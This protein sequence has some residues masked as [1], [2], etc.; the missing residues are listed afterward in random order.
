[1]RPDL[2]TEA[3]AKDYASLMKRCD[4]V[5]RRADGNDLLAARRQGVCGDRVA[6]VSPVLRRRQVRRRRQRPAAVSSARRITRTAASRRPTSSIRWRRSS[7]CSARRS[8]KSFLEPFMNYA[9]SDRWKFPFAPHDLGT[10]PKANGQ[11]YGG[12]EKTEENQMPVEESGNMLL[13]MAALAQM[14]GNADFASQYWPQLTAVGRVPEATRVRSREPA[15]HRRLRRATWR[16]TS[17]CRR[18]RSVRWARM[19]S[20]ARCAATTSRRPSTARSREEFAARW[21]KEADDG[22]HYRLTFDR[23]GTWSQKYNLVWDK[24]LGLNLFPDEVRRKEMDFYLKIAE[25]LRPAARQPECL[26]EA[27]LDFVDGD[28]DA[29]SRGLRR[30]GDARLSRSS[31][32]RPIVRR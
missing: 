1:M 10:Y 27:R 11:V 28:A 26:H 7:C 20:S 2:L 29:G 4:E 24:L 25:Q 23:P 12:G 15:L 18:R 17:T 6:G 21:I 8:T 16:T 13:L 5:R 31:T 14:E 32:R 30:A 19:R 3:S 9:A 22:D